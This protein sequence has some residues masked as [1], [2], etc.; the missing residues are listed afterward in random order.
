MQ[1]RTFYKT[2][3]LVFAAIAILALAWAFSNIGFTPAT[4]QVAATP[5][6]MS[7]LR[8]PNV[9][10][11]LTW[12]QVATLIDTHAPRVIEYITF[13]Q[14]VYHTRNGRYW[15]GL[16]MHTT[17][18]GQAAEVYPDRFLVAPTDQRSSWG[19]I[20]FLPFSP[21]NYTLKMD[22]YNGEQGDG[23]VLC[24]QIVWGGV[25]REKCWQDGPETW[26]AHDWQEITP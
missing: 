13:R 8:I 17:T 10:S 19:D 22:V 5:T 14:D 2:L 11:N 12:A 1:P 24:L 9:R 6:Q 23:W 25:N 20:R 7:D 21:M 26:R 18:P 3:S 15:Q 16:K 4:G